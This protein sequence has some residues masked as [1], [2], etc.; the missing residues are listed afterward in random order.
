MTRVHI[1]YVSEPTG[2]FKLIGG[3][4][5]AHSLRGWQSPVAA[6]RMQAEAMAMQEGTMVHFRPRRSLMT[7]AGMMSRK[8]TTAMPAKMKP[9]EGRTR[10]PYPSEKQQ[11]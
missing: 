6:I 5:Q 8:L 3:R 4:L 1:P 2:L 10:E 7:E 11:H 9:G